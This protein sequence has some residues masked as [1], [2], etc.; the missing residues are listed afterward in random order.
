MCIFAAYVTD[1]IGCA[2]CP[3][4]AKASAPKAKHWIGDVGLQWYPLVELYFRQCWCLKS[5][6]VYPYRYELSLALLVDP[7]NY[8]RHTGPLIH[9]Q[10]SHPCHQRIL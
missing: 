1:D 8:K 5:K 9:F 3:C 2:S 6:E 10:C 4:V 7:E